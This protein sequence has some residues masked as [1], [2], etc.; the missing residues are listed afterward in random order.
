MIACLPVYR[1]YITGPERGRAAR[2]RASSRRPSTTAKRRNPRTAEAI[3]DFV[4]DT[5][6]LRNLDEFREADR[7]R[8]VDWVDEASS[9]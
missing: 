6:L 9:R 2:P 4:R 7:P 3:F 8:L 1:T 5:L